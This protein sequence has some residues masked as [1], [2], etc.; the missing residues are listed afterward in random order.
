[1]VEEEEDEDEDMA[2]LDISMLVD[3]VVAI[4][5]SM[6]AVHQELTEARIDLKNGDPG[7][8]CFY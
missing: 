8:M 1:M 4:D 6:I 2:V 7:R 3:V 5:M